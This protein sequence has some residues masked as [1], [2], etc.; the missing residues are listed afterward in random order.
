[1]KA[2]GLKPQAF[3]NTKTVYETS[4]YIF[5]NKLDILVLPL[6]PKK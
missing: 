4:F 2:C 5:R 1:M 3:C 6:K